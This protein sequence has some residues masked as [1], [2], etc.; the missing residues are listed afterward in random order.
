MLLA[1]EVPGEEDDDGEEFQSADDHKCAEV[2]LQ[3]RMEECEVAQR[4]NGTEPGTGIGQH[5]KG[6]G[7]TRL[8]IQALQGNDQG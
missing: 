6:S 4:S 3:G 2:K 7:D 8:H 1:P 5:T